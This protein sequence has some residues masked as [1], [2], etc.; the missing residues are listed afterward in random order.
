MREFF[1][2]MIGDLNGMYG[3]MS[4]NPDLLTPRP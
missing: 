2:D 4:V 3:V 1:R